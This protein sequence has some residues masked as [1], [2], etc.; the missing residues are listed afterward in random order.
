M[1]KVELPLTGCLRLLAPGPVVLLSAQYR[2]RPG[3]MAAAWL[4]PAGY[5]PPLVAVAVSP[6][7]NT[8]Y[9]IGKAQEFVLNIPGRPL[10]EQVMLAG[11]LS[12][13]DVDKFARSGLT[14]VDGRRVTAPWVS[15]CLAHLE[16]GLLQAHDLP[17]HTLFIGEVVG[18]WAEEEAY[19]GAWTLAAD[20][21]CPLLH[22]GAEHF[23]VP[24]GRFTL[25]RPAAEE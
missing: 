3:L 5:A 7:A 21:L 10:A 12:G 4:A 9:L 20:E 17:D 23:A 18:A 25:P 16:C 1:A 13:R 14:P 22:L 24:A 11:T 19:D 15:E 8:H 6:L 2:G